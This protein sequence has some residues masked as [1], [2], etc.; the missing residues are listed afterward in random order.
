MNPPSGIE[1]SGTKI[2][3]YSELVPDVTEFMTM[4]YLP[5]MLPETGVNE[6]FEIPLSTS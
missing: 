4:I 2:K 3:L 1:L 6:P 5:S